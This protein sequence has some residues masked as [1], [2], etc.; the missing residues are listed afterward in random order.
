MKALIYIML[1]F[2]AS[3]N[4]IGQTTLEKSQSTRPG[5]KVKMEF[6][7]PE[8]VS[9]KT[10]D[11]NEIKIAASVSINNGQNDDAFDV[12]INDA[13]GVL[14]IQSIIN[15]YDEIPRRIMFSRNGE[16][17]FFNTSDWNSPEVQAFLAKYGKNGY[18]HSSSGVIKDI[19]LTITVPKNITLDI[20]SKFSTVEINGFSGPLAIYSK[21]GEVDLSVSAGSKNEIQAATKFGEIYSD[22]QVKFLGTAK[23]N[24]TIG[25]RTMVTAQVNGGGK[26]QQVESKFGDVYIRNSK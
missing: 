23:G 12:T 17:H 19:K 16:K 4:A 13:D 3:L 9:I 18:H 8:L 1:L 22:L 2:V 14:S 25:K 21:F 5:Q 7:Y 11:R 26:M 10:W 20:E 15:N 6:K 24:P